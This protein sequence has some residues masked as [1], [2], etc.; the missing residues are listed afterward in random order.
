MGTLPSLAQ[1]PAANL[2]G[3]RSGWAEVWRTGCKK[4]SPRPKAKLATLPTQR[5]LSEVPPSI[6]YATSAQQR[7]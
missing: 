4:E 7:P 1:S 5:T 2:L 3:S 6:D